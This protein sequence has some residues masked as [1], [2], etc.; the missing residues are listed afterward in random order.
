M[1][2]KNSPYTTFEEMA[3]CVHE[4]WIFFFQ[5]YTYAICFFKTMQVQCSSGL[6]MIISNEN[7]KNI[8]Y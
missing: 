2:E 3:Y 4:G 7:L 1:Y 5:I 8:T 6:K